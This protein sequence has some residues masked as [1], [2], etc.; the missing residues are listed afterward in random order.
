MTKEEHIKYW[1]ETSEEDWNV[2]DALYSSNKY[3][4]SLFFSHLL[5]EKLAKALWVKHNEDNFPPK[6]HNIVL[7]LEQAEIEMSI[8]QKKFFITMNDFQLEG[9]YPDYKNKI[10]KLI[11]KKD[12][13]EI[14]SKVKQEREWLLKKLQ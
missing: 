14:L 3:L 10:Y 1:I 12:T 7:L 5:L 6:I 4:Y 2:V 9:R 11:T 13:D 8:D